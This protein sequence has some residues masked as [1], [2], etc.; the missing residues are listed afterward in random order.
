M[1]SRFAASVIIVDRGWKVMTSELAFLESTVFYLELL[2]MVI[3]IPFIIYGAYKMF[4]GEEEE[5]EK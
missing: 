1:R 5:K 2:V 4:K 3:M